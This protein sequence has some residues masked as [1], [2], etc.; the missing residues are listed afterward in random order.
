MK[1]E[2]A[3]LRKVFIGGLDYRTTTE[4]LKAYFEKYGELLDVVVMMDTKTNRSRGFGFVAFSHSSM[5]DDVQKDRPHSIDGRT[6]DTKRAV[7]KNRIG[8]P[9]T[10]TTVKKL[11]VGGLK[12]DVD[13]EVSF[14]AQI[15]CNFVIILLKS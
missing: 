7:P 15:I 14:F 10:G 2:P 6:V 9:E 8:K 13:E 12:D 4:S 3:Y 1:R 11:F 5:V